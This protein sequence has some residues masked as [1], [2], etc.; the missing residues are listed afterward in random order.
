MHAMPLAINHFIIWL[1]SPTFIYV[2]LKYKRFLTRTGFCKNEEN[3]AHK[4]M[5]RNI[6]RGW[7]DKR[8]QTI[9]CI[10]S[11]SRVNK[12][13]N[14]FFQISIPGPVKPT[15]FKFVIYTLFNGL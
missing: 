12:N 5:D 8:K 1:L 10:Y 14:K 4:R 11:F 6:N 13:K 2:F 15:K 3:P 7:K 9:H